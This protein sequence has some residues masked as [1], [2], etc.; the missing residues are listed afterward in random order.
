MLLLLRVVADEG[1]PGVSVAILARSNSGTRA[2]RSSWGFGGEGRD[3]IVG[4]FSPRSLAL[5][6]SLS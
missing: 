6:L 2:P 3:A 5:S 1:L 4:F